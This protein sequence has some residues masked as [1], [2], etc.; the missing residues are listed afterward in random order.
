MSWTT[1]NAPAIFTLYV[2]IMS[3]CS[4]FRDFW[5]AVLSRLS[6]IALILRSS[7]SHA[8]SFSWYTLNITCSLCSIVCRRCLN[9]RS[10]SLST[11]SI[12]DSIVDSE[13]EGVKSNRLADPSDAEHRLLSLAKD[14][15]LKKSYVNMYKWVYTKVTRHMS[16]LY[17]WVGNLYRNC[18]KRMIWNRLAGPTEICSWSERAMMTSPLETLNVVFGPTC[19]K[20]SYLVSLIDGG[21]RWYLYYLWIVKSSIVNI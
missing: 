16:I 21:V 6:P 12:S 5:A 4:S 7:L 15:E 14:L 3:I 11:V 20:I 19:R 8:F 17:T 1:F 13:G 18:T 10:L 9:S 2:C